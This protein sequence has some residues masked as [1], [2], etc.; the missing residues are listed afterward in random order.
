[1]RIL[2]TV[3][4]LTAFHLAADASA[5]APAADRV[6]DHL[7]EAAK[8]LRR[9]DLVKAEQVL[10]KAVEIDS[11]RSD[12]KVELAF[13]LTKQRR[14]LEA[15][16]ILLPIA[17][18]EPKNA[19]AFAVF[20]T[21]M[22]AGGRFSEAT[23]L[24]YTAIVQNKK[25][26][27]GWAGYG[28]IDFYENR[29]V[30]SLDKLRKAVYLRP[31]EPDY[32]FALA[33]VCARSE[34]YGEA[35][36]NYKRFLQVSENTDADRRARIKGLIEFLNYLGLRSTLYGLS[37]AESSV[38]P[39]EL[40]GNRPVIKLRVNG[41]PEVLNFVLDTGSGISVVSEQTAKRMKIKRVTKGGFA[42][43]LGG[44]GKFEI[45]YGMLREVALGD[46]TIKN[47]PVY[48]REFHQPG[49]EVDGYIGLGLISKFLTTVDYG[50]LTISLTR[51]DNDLRQ[52]TDSE[53][54]SQPLRL[55]SSGFLSG[56]VKLEGIQAPL[57][58]IVDT[59]ASISVISDEVARSERISR[60]AGDDKLRVVGSAGITDDKQT[61]K[62]PKVTFGK[63]TREDVLAVALDL[64]LINEASGF[65]QAGILGGNFLKNYR[66]TFDF[67][68]SKVIFVPL[69]A[70]KD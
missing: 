50:N 64:G 60:F 1:V 9:A 32:V 58:F 53:D 35:A 5:S 68:N 66:L 18:A 28:L 34:R 44:S 36:E 16:E 43:G 48:L 29:I 26:H 49:Q 47:V 54:L 41:R 51:R 39:F 67:K 70:E 19:R 20:G 38:V 11:S 21:T 22:L 2:L 30:D 42:R 55:T 14:L 65:E 4:F 25:E 56:E 15:Y 63:N 13:V 52:F 33:Q 12:A 62:L 8:L 69:Q 46:L 37:G 57:N 6:S 61:Y 59:G 23:Q 45:V 40:V 27:L 24:F 7:K 17:Q 10:R 3:F 31:D